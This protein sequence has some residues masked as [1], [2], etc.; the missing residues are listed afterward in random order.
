METQI[1]HFLNILSGITFHANV[2]PLLIQR[3]QLRHNER[4]ASGTLVALSHSIK[5]RP[6]AHTGA[7]CA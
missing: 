6:G 3:P 2:T 7:E 4:T 5:L 1:S